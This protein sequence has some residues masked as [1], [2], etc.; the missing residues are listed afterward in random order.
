MTSVPARNLVIEIIGGR[1]GVLDFATGLGLIVSA[2]VTLRA[3]E[4]DERCAG[5]LQHYLSGIPIVAALVLPFAGLELALD[6]DLGALAE[7]PLGD[8]DKAVTEDGDGVSFGA[9]FAFAGLL[10]LPAFACGDAEVC[11]LAAVLE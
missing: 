9:L 2:F 5:A 10:V 1:T 8:T 11:D 3:V 7:I 6:V 4:H